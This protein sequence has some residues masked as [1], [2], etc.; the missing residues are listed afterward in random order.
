MD[1]LSAECLRETLRAPRDG[2]SG[3][4]QALVTVT[5]E[6]LLPAEIQEVLDDLFL[7]VRHIH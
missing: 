1:T 2:V 6:L 3:D 5:S 7:G 4:K